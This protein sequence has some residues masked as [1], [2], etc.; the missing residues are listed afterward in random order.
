MNKF[1]VYGYFRED[2]T[3]YYIG[4]GTGKRA[5]EKHH[6]GLLPKDASRIK[7]LLVDLTEQEAFEGEMDLISLLGRKD[8]GTGCLRNMTDGGEGGPQGRILSKESRAKLS[9]AMKGRKHSEEARSKMSLLKKGWK[10]SQATKDKR[11][12]SCK[13]R[14]LWFHPDYGWEWAAIIELAS[15]HNR[16]SASA[17][18]NLKAGRR[19]AIKGWRVVS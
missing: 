3:P 7:L 12:E 2:G 18:C 11:A 1:Y 6:R 17:L 14:T 8:N 19:N 9:A 5:W 4:K 10:Q 15:M 13:K 16:P